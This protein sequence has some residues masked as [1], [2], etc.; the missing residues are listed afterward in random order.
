MTEEEQVRL[1]NIAE[2]DHEIFAL[3]K[4]RWSPRA[5]RDEHLSQDTLKKIFEAARWSSSYNNEQPW[6]F[7]YAN[8]GSEGYE[9]ITACLSDRDRKWALNAP[10]LV[11]TAF[12]QK[13]KDNKDNHCAQ[14]DL[15][16]SLGNMTMQ[17]QYMGIALHQISEIDWKKAKTEFD[18][19]EGYHI[20]TVVALG[21]YG[22]ELESLS[23]EFQEE[24]T[25]ERT[26]MPQANFAYHNSWKN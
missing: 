4:Q 22:G 3:L 8:K 9:K 18:I 19:P 6:R 5:F 7:I 15:G 2:T 25:R 20:S 24:E 21:Y 13:D 26:R 10:T 14:L 11:L 17:A 1:H 12:K 16:L 23:P